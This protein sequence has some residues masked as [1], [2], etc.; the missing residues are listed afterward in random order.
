MEKL[1]TLKDLRKDRIK[2]FIKK[3]ESFGCPDTFLKPTARKIALEIE[4]QDRKEAIGLKIIKR[5][6]NKLNLWI[7]KWFIIA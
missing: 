3:L 1:K 5:E 4:K 2:Y 6:L 7:R